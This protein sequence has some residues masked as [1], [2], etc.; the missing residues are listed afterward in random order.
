MRLVHQAHEHGQKVLKPGDYAIDATIGNGHDTVFLAKCVGPT[1]CVWGIDIQAIA[2][3][4]TRKRLQANG[5]L[6]QTRLI[7]GNHAD[8]NTHIPSFAFGHIRLICFNLGY[9]PGQDHTCTTQADSTLQ[10]LE[11]AQQLLAPGGL[12]SCLVY[13]GHPAG[14][15]EARV[16]QGFFEKKGALCTTYMS[17]QPNPTSPI[18]YCYTKKPE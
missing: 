9:L 1:G 13:P 16:V 5:G 10:A 18:L 6:A 8:L 14:A 11:Q 12:I 2:L 7:L 17:L 15:Q 3:E 4:N